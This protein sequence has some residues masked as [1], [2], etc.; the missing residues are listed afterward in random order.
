MPLS[1]VY[2]MK[3]VFMPYYPRKHQL[4]DN[5]AYHI[6]NRGNGRRTIFHEDRDY[7]YFMR[8]LRKYSSTKNVSIYHWV[9][10]P[11]HYHILLEINM[12]EELSSV[13]AGIN[14]SYSN[15]Y[16]KKYKTAGYLW[17]GRFGSRPIQKNKYLSTC[18]RY[19][20]RNP[21]RKNLVKY[22]EKYKYSS[23]RYYITG[24]HDGLT[25][26]TPFYESLGSNKKEKQESY[27]LFLLDSSQQEEKIYH[28]GNKPIGDKAFKLSLIK[29]KGHYVPKR[30]GRPKTKW[31][32]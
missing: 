21:L 29:K 17:Q 19:I 12:P 4:H 27:R 22:A 5:I 31:S 9:I 7:G 14:K 18:G 20:E 28:T 8:L 23:A 2:S 30:Q 24:H 16:H 15:Y 6:F 11:N 13:M 32:V 25:T 1:S 3:E 26:E 10:I